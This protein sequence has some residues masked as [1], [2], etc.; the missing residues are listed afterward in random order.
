[1]SRVRKARSE[2]GAL[3]LDVDPCHRLRFN[4]AVDVIRRGAFSHFPNFVLHPLWGWSNLDAACGV[5][6]EDKVRIG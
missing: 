5:V 2:G 1:M 3:I 6:S 4:G